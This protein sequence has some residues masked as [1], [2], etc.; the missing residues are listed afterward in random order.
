MSKIPMLF[1]LEQC[2]SSYLAHIISF[3]TPE[4]I[5]GGVGMITPSNLPF[6]SI[7]FSKL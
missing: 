2:I 1:Y 6:C 3:Q 7:N 4:S 5:N